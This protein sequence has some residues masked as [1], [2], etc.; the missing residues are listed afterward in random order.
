MHWT[1]IGNLLP[2]FMPCSVDAGEACQWPVVISKQLLLP[3]SLKMKHHEDISEIDWISA[4]K[5]PPPQWMS[6]MRE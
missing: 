4:E 5:L 2:L 1:H 6:P 3:F